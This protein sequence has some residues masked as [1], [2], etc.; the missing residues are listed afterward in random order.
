MCKCVYLIIS[1]ETK[2]RKP[3]TKSCHNTADCSVLLA[4]PTP[5]KLQRLIRLNPKVLRVRQVVKRRL[6]FC[7][8]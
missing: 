1:T 2:R 7:V 8:R 4:N 3:H 6:W 5:L